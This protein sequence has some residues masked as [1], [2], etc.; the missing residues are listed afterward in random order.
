MADENDELDIEADEPEDSPEDSGEVAAEAA[1][2]KEFFSCDGLGFKDVQRFEEALLRHRITPDRL[3]ST[4]DTML[5]RGNNNIRIRA[6]D[7]VRKF[8]ELVYGTEIRLKTD[9]LEEESTE[10]L[11]RREDEVAQKI[12]ALARTQMRVL[13]RETGSA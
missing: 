1:A 3:L 9:L 5:V 8:V 11:K 7:A 12:A 6:L 4:I 10:E 2:L 13:D